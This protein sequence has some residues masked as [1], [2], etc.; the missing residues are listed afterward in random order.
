MA[1]DLEET[2]MLARNRDSHKKNGKYYKD[3]V[4]SLRQ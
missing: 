4:S 1:I 2:F 3:S